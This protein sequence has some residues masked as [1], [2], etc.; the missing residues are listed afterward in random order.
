MRPL[1]VD[2][3]R[4]LGRENANLLQPLDAK[5]GR[6]LAQHQVFAGN[7]KDVAH[8]FDNVCLEGIDAIWVALTR[9]NEITLYPFETKAIN[10]ELHYKGLP[11]IDPTTLLDVP[12]P[13]YYDFMPTMGFSGPT[14]SVS[15]DLKQLGSLRPYLVATTASTWATARFQILPAET[16]FCCL[17]ITGFK[18]IEMTDAVGRAIAAPS[19]TTDIAVSDVFLAKNSTVVLYTNDSDLHWHRYFQFIG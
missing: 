1:V 15:G 13:N 10:F 6:I 9:N 17:N 19:A 3:S 7:D 16:A 5:T 4:H 12:H 8:I 18:G 11:V 14:P 2:G